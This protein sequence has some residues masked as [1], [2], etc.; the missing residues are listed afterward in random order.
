MFITLR[1]HLFP[2][3]TQKLS[4]VIA[5]NTWRVTAWEDRFVRQHKNLHFLVKVFLFSLFNSG[6]HECCKMPFN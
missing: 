2:S 4:S 3:R 6:C 1:F 5:D